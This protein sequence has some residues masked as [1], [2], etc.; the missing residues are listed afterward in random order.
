MET[1]HII[2]KENYRMTEFRIFM[3]LF[4]LDDENARYFFK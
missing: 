4:V 3:V 2:Y 1:A